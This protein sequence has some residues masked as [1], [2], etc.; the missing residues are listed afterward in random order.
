MMF[1]I[2][3]QISL[4]V[5]LALV[6]GEGVISTLLNIGNHLSDVC[7]LQCWNVTMPVLKISY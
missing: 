1:Q 5:H 3:D 4:C 2:C 7:F 6:E